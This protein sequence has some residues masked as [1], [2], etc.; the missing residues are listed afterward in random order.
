MTGLSPPS[1]EARYRA[2]LQ[3]DLASARALES[4]VEALY[5][6]SW[7]VRKVASERLAKHPSP[8]RVITRLVQVLGDPGKPGARNAAASALVGLGER[9]VGA[10]I[11]LLD[12]GDPDQRKFASEILGQARSQAAV[13]PLVD[14]LQDPDLNVR[15]AVA[16]ALGLIGGDE[17]LRALTQ[18]LGEQESVVKLAALEALAAQRRAPPL[19]VVAPLLSDP[20][21]RKT[22]YRVLALIGEPA[23]VELV[24]RGLASPMRSVRETALAALGAQRARIEPA[25]RGELEA[26]V[27]AVL[28]RVADVADVVLHAL[29]GDDGEA[30][31][32]ALFVAGYLREPALSTAVAECA[33]DD[34]LADEVVATLVRIGPAAAG[35]LLGSLDSFSVPARAAASAALA[36]IADPAVALDVL[37]KTDAQDIEGSLWAVKALGRSTGEAAIEALVRALAVPRAVQAAVKALERLSGRARET[38]LRALEGEGAEHA[39]AGGLLA[40]ARFGR[41]RALP[42]LKAALRDPDVVLRRA[43]A[44]ALSEIGVEEGAELVRLAMADE[45]TEVRI[46]A[47]RSLGHAGGTPELIQLGLSDPDRQ[48]RANAV[49]SA[50]EAMALDLAPRIEVL[51]QDPDGPVAQRAVR[52]LAKLGRLTP[53]VLRRAASHADPE[54]LKECLRAGAAMAAGVSLAQTLVGH[55]GWDVR[56]EAARVLAASGGRECLEVVDRALGREVDPLVREAL[57]EAVRRL[58]KR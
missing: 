42:A 52:A 39:S 44:D 18:V 57:G 48:V 1:E 15:V 46:A 25:R 10:M 2:L 38:I 47:A 6:E 14:R 33:S 43:A 8:Q 16:E 29:E 9:A 37:G 22:A 35:E 55:P 19:P 17:A 23:A 34:A 26:E 56:V 50:G 41:A 3:I 40:L 36:E 31:A 7:R 51:T 5:D 27:E 21:L 20:T 12:R 54:V 53:E 13:A 45:A 30:K 32:G 49:E 58:E 11:E 28:G 24:C 4:L